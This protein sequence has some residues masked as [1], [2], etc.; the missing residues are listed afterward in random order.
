[1]LVPELVLVTATVLVLVLVLLASVAH[2]DVWL[3]QP[4]ASN[5]LVWHAWKLSVLQ[6]D[7]QRQGVP[8][9]E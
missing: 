7:W 2:D 4:L 3:A 1:M 8:G 5:L 9:S 6:H